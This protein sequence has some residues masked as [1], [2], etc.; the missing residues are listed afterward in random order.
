M[1]QQENF[2]S[3]AKDGIISVALDSRRRFRWRVY[4]IFA[5]LT[6]VHLTVIGFVL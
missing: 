1:D 5:A 2:R 4:P 6:I 3:Y